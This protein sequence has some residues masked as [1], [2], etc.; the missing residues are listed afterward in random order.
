M[1]NLI[2][3]NLVVHERHKVVTLY[4]ILGKLSLITLND[5]HIIGVHTRLLKPIDDIDV[6]Y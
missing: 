5:G 6:F 3:G 1:N 4:E 2:E